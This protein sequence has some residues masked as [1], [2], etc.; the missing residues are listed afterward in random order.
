MGGSSNFNSY[1]A[2]LQRVL[3]TEMLD[4]HIQRNQKRRLSIVGPCYTHE[5]WLLMQ[6]E[7]KRMDEAAAAAAIKPA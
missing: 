1:H 5:Q 2:T 3:F 6:A 4:E 7:R